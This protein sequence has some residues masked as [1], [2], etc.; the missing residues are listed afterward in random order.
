MLTSA[1]FRAYF[2][3]TSSLCLYRIHS[4]A[5]SSTRSFPDV[6]TV[7]LIH[8][9]R[10]GVRN[11]LTPQRFPNLQ[12]IHYLSAHPG[13]TDIYRRFKK[14]VEWVFPNR[15]YVFYNCMMDAGMGRIDN[16]LIRKYIERLHIYP[17]E[18]ELNLPGYGRYNGIDYHSHLLRCLKEPY[19]PSSPEIPILKSQDQEYNPYFDCGDANSFSSYLELKKEDDFFTMIMEDCEEEEKNNEYRLCHYP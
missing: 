2:Q 15:K 3:Q 17:Y 18:I 8:C 13:Q 11:V 4:E 9:S 12:T 19:T 1:I 14:P 5:L 10:V 6:H 16:H 7:S